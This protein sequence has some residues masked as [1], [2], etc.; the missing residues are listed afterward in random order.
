M[1]FL[2]GLPVGGTVECCDS[3]PGNGSCNVGGAT[4]GPFCSTELI[5]IN[6]DALPTP[7]S[8]HLLQLQSPDGPLSNEIPICVDATGFNACL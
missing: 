5:R 8:T 1:I 7:E 2:N 3:I 4:F 6:L